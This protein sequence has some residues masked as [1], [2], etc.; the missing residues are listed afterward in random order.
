MFQCSQKLF[1]IPEI[2]ITKMFFICSTIVVNCC[3]ENHNGISQEKILV[4]KSGV[5]GRIEFYTANIQSKKCFKTEKAKL[6]F[7]ESAVDQFV[8][9]KLQNLPTTGKAYHFLM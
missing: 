8:L 9:S 2:Y 5:D 1:G 6:P 7:Q 3:S 4:M